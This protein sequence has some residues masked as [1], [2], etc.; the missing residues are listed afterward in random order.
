M[1][2]DSF[3]QLNDRCHRA[4]ASKESGVDGKANDFGDDLAKKN[5]ARVESVLNLKIHPWF[6]PSAR[7]PNGGG[8]IGSRTVNGRDASQVIDSELSSEFPCRGFPGPT[9][10]VGTSG[11]LIIEGKR[12]LRYAPQF[13]T[14]SARVN[15]G[16]GRVKRLKVTPTCDRIVY[17]RSPSFNRTV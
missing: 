12:M 10:T 17:T 8:V 14:A 15:P 6:K 13:Y 7:N 4:R 2:A 1:N 9:L 3:H 5:R 11:S 16:C